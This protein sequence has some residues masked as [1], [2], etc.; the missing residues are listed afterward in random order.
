MKAILNGVLQLSTL[1]GWV[2][3]AADMGIGKIFG[4]VPPS[5]YIG[6]ENDN[7]MD[8]DAE[9]LYKSLE[10]LVPLYYAT[11]RGNLTPSKWIDMM[12]NSIAASSYFNTQRMVSEYRQEIWEM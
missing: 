10:E 6:T 7:K 5:G 9:N 12:I 4:Y 2:V 3:E 1:D 8:E 11:A